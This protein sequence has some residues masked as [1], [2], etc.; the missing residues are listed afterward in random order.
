MVTDEKF[1]EAFK[2]LMN[3]ILDLELRC[4]ALN[5][6]LEK[7]IPGSRGEVDSVSKQMADFPGLQK[8][9]RDIESL[10]IADALEA[11]ANYDG[12]LQ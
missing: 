8:V 5:M 7:H 3:R 6:V 2:F 1:H 12:P 11:F 9:R 4:Q 10:E